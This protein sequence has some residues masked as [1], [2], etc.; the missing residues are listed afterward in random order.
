MNSGGESGAPDKTWAKCGSH[1]DAG[2][3][4]WREN[5][6]DKSCHCPR[7]KESLNFPNEWISDNLSA[8]P[9]RNEFH[10]NTAMSH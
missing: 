5:K 7:C 6:H 4:L 3:I 2:G 9:F 10:D 1:S 8:C